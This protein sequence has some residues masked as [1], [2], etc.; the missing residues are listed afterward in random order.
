VLNYPE[1]GLIVQLEELEKNIAHIAASLPKCKYAFSVILPEKD[2][3]QLCDIY[4]K[5]EKFFNKPFLQKPFEF[6]WCH[7]KLLTETCAR[8]LT[9]EERK[10]EA[11]IATKLGVPKLYKGYWATFPEILKSLNLESKR[12]D[13]GPWCVYANIILHAGIIPRYFE[14]LLKKAQKIYK[15]YYGDEKHAIQD[16]FDAN[17]IVNDPHYSKYFKQAFGKAEAIERMYLCRWL[18]W[19]CRFASDVKNINE[20]PGIP[21]ALAYIIR[22]NVP[23]NR[24]FLPS[25][26]VESKQSNFLFNYEEGHLELLLSLNAAL[27]AADQASTFTIDGIRP[28]HW[29]KPLQEAVRLGTYSIRLPILP[30]ELGKRYAFHLHEGQRIGYI[31]SAS[32]EFSVVLFNL[33]TM[34]VIPPDNTREYRIDIKN[35]IGI[36][37]KYILQNSKKS[38]FRTVEGGMGCIWGEWY[39][40]HHYELPPDLLKSS[41]RIEL[42]NPYGT[43]TLTPSAS[44]KQM[45][46]KWLSSKKLPRLDQANNFGGTMPPDLLLCSNYSTKN[47]PIVIFYFQSSRASAPTEIRANVNPFNSDW[48]CKVSVP[49]EVKKSPYWEITAR[50]YPSL[51]FDAEDNYNADE[52]QCTWHPG[53]TINIDRKTLTFPGTQVRISLTAPSLSLKYPLEPS[54]LIVENNHVAWSLADD[55]GDNKLL[56]GFNSSSRFHEYVFRLPYLQVFLATS[57]SPA[58]SNHWCSAAPFKKNFVEK[59]I[60]DDHNARFVFICYCPSQIEIVDKLHKKL[61]KVMDFSTT[62]KFIIRCSEIFYLFYN[63]DAQY[64]PLI[65]CTTTNETAPLIV[66]ISKCTLAFT[67]IFKYALNKYIYK[68]RAFY[69][70]RQ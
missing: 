70:G 13:G 17:N 53:V 30:E 10:L 28:S 31:I 64:D 38:G 1:Q 51:L 9:F 23:S 65:V 60:K 44:H 39:G 46:G 40:W 21:P 29:T 67:S 66:N 22:N 24:H 61:F 27:T 18:I 32:S 59:I 2:Y 45:V 37:S 34:V 54:P 52:F 48:L 15:D 19:I 50:V 33:E 42:G 20:M 43:I 11:A 69:Y 3:S 68:E 16:L 35:G 63:S 6:P 26:L 7:V 55:C 12:E 41:M 14:S 57:A 25:K 5:T 58:I 4:R 56:I 8:Y 62:T 36:L 49:E 47:P